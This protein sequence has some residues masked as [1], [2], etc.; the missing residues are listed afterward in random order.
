MLISLHELIKK[1][2][3]Q[4]NGI[5]HVGAHECEELNDYLR[6]IP[7][8]KILWVEALPEKVNLCKQKYSG[9]LIE[10]AIVSD[11]AEKVR[12]N[13]SNNG[14]S[15]SLLEFGLHSHFHPHVHYIGYFE[16][17]TK[18]LKDI[19]PNYNI[20]YNF[21]NLDIQGAELKALKG[22]EEY[23]N[24]VDY[25]YT[26]VNSDY[27]YKNCALVTELDEYLL[28]FGLHRVETQWCEDFRWGDAFYIRK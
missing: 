23:L 21:I 9:L 10:N 18:L 24:G 16:S 12:F 6:Y 1:Y 3:I 26:E 13:I 27:V 20:S 22:M 14:Q 17:E 8:E 15:S 11:V 25:L 4:I 19:L 7:I 2:N 5:L 28:K